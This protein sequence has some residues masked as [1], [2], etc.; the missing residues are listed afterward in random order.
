M[1]CHYLGFIVTVNDY[2]TTFILTDV[3]NFLLYMHI[4][5][6]KL[7]EQRDVTADY[8]CGSGQSRHTLGKKQHEGYNVVLIFFICIGARL[9]FL[10]FE[11]LTLWYHSLYQ[12]HSFMVYFVFF[13]FYMHRSVT[14]NFLFLSY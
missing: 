10:F 4:V 2:N 1:W 12:S 13:L 3:Y 5:T 6:N 7:L 8:A 11:E 14:S 9:L